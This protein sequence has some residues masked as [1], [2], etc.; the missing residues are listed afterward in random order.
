[1][2]KFQKTKKKFDVIT[3]LGLFEFLTDEEILFTV[4]KLHEMLNDGGKLFTT[5]N[6]ESSMK[7]LEKIISLFGPVDYAIINI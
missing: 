2:I 5:L 3:I 6:N 1:M 4:N 7:Y